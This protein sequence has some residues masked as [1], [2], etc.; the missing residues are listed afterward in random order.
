MALHKLPIGIQSFE[1]L[2]SN[3]YLYVDKTDLV[4]KLV[5]LDYYYFLSRP[6]RFGKSLLLSTI[7]AYFKGQKE[8]F[9]GLAISQLEHDWVEYP[10]FHLDLNSQH[11]ES[12]E[13]LN[14]M[15][16]SALSEWGAQ[17]G[18]ALKGDSPSIRFGNLIRDIKKVTGKSV[19]LLI[20]EYDQPILQNITNDALQEEM[21]NK[22]R[23]FYSVVKSEDSSIRFAIFTGVTRFGRLGIFSGLN[24]L[25]DISMHKEYSTICGIT[26]DEIDKYFVDDLQALA[27]ENN[28]SYEEAREKCRKNYDGYRFCRKSPRLYNPYSLLNAL[29]NREYG[30][31]W[32]TSGTPS[33]FFNFLKNNLI[34]FSKIDAV[35]ASES[36][37]SDIETILT[38]PI[39]VLYQTGYL[40]IKDYDEMFN[41]YVLGFPNKEVEVGFFNFLMKSYSSSADI[42]G[43]FDVKCFVQ[44][45][46]SGDV[47]QFMHR[48]KA[49][50]ADVPYDNKLDTEANF[51]NLIYVLFRLISVY[52][53][54]EQ[55]TSFGRLDMVALTTQRIYIFEFKVDA[56]AESAL[57][58]IDE[59]H[60]ADPY[61]ADGRQIVKLGVNFVTEQ[62]NIEQWIVE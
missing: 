18:V 31:Y 41:S 33:C 22:L 56:T 32:V 61:L 39:P 49:F 12:I 47:E 36:K 48:L 13:D 4:Y 3:G 51:R 25:L 16:D 38:E 58:Q 40:T 35:N 26:D 5:S 20:D 45:I 21:R 19:V 9:E 8:L 23:A 24:N 10:V 52:V 37:L 29:Y 14:V 44:D 53:K 15:L 27:D 2:R 6:R 50:I 60:Y 34:D 7:E 59:K 28:V 30:S 57:K 62:R 46:N 42:E 17:Y 1:K 43:S 55:H 11:Y 54:V